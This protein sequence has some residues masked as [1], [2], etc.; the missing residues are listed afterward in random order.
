ML[1]EKTHKWEK[2]YI[3]ITSGMKNTYT[4]LQKKIHYTTS[5]DNFDSSNFWFSNYRVYTPLKG[6]LI[7]HITW[8][9]YMPYRVKWN[10]I[11]MAYSLRSKCT[12]NCG[13]QTSTVKNTVKSWVVYFLKHSVE[14][15]QLG[16]VTVYLNSCST[17]KTNA[18]KHSYT[19]KCMWMSTSR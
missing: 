6:G 19:A 4:V 11:S 12:K 15:T 10:H 1:L 18:S 17:S 3:P 7:F 5:A 9:V 16:T 8:L 2:F 13:I 14:H